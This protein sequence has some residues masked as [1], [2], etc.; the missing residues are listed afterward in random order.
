M[1]KETLQMD[2]GKD[3]EMWRYNPGLSMWA[4][5]NHEG[6]YKRV[7]GGIRVRGKAK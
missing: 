6:A 1:A 5:C 3:F 4:Q 7:A 2:Q